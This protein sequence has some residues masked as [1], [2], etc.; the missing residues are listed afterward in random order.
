MS[1]TVNYDEFE[2][3]LR[4]SLGM[5][6]IKPDALDAG[7]AIE[8]IDH[9]YGKLKEKVLDVEAVG[10]V[11]ISS[12]NEEA[13]DRIYPDLE[14]NYKEAFKVFYKQ[15]PLIV[16]FWG[17]ESGKTD[18][19][20]LLRTIRGKIT[21]GHGL[22]DSIRS[23]IP[24]PGHKEKYNEMTKK[25]ETGNLEAEDYIELCKSLV[26]IPEN[27][28]EFSGLFLS[29]DESEIRDIFGPTKALEL[30][31]KFEDILTIRHE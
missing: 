15:G 24:L 20:D 8:L 30:K 9:T 4:V 11:L 7:I 13:V 25:L 12:F 6:L 16:V 3:N 1:E 26:H 27:I 28:K 23:I 18:L 22:E 5:M 19:W 29:I 21:E 2:H 31:T 10:A 17:S 14:D